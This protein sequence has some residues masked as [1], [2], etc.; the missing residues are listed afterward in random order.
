MCRRVADFTVF[1]IAEVPRVNLS[2]FYDT[3][4]IRVFS[5]PGQKLSLSLTGFRAAHTPTALC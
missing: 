2:F 3:L 5:D 1:Q 4:K